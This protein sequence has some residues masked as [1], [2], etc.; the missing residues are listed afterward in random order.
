MT[1]TREIEKKREAAR[2]RA[3]KREKVEA[4]SRK[5][6]NNAR[7]ENKE[8]GVEEKVSTQNVPIGEGRKIKAVNKMERKKKENCKKEVVVFY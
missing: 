3:E 1:N 7:S 6:K 5:K 4:G 2:L 8:S